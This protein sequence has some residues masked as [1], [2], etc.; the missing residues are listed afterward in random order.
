VF[1]T[2][3]P[4]QR[5]Q[6]WIQNEGGDVPYASGAA[7]AVHLPREALRVL[8]DTGTPVSMTTELEDAEAG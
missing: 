3:A 2:L 6:V 1:V 7:V 8:P 5:I 4:G